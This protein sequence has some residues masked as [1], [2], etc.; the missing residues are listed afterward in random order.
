MKILLPFLIIAVNLFVF[1][2]IGVLLWN[3]LMPN[4]FSLPK[5]TYLQFLGLSVLVRLAFGRI[6]IKI[7]KK[8]N[9]RS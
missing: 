4:I 7:G 6:S 1:S 8:Q 9:L 3:L 2:L 5:L